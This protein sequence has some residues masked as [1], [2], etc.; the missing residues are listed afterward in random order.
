MNLWPEV[1][2]NLYIIYR[3]EYGRHPL[4]PQLMSREL[5]IQEAISKSEESP[6]WYMSSESVWDKWG[7]FSEF[8]NQVAR[9]AIAEGINISANLNEDQGLIRIVFHPRK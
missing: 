4:P 6:D 1:E 2:M 7:S 3:K 9:M 8:Q 5:I